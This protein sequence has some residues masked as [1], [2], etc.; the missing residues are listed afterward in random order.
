MCWANINRKRATITVLISGKIDFSTK[1][2]S[3][4]DE[5]GDYVMIKEQI[6]QEDIS[7]LNMYIPNKILG[8]PKYMKESLIELQRGINKSIFLV[9]DFNIYLDY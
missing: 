1:I 9:R 4:K 7:M 6:H 8:T 3:I 2:L 5:K